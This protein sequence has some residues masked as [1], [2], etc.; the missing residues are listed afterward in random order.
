MM[1]GFLEVLHDCGGYASPRAIYSD[2]EAKIAEAHYS[3]DMKVVM[4][5]HR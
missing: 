4:V 3:F 2:D 1:P 5:F